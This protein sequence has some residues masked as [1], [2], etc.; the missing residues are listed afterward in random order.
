MTDDVRRIAESFRAHFPARAPGHRRLGREAEHPV[1][2][3]DGT[4]FDVAALWSDLAEGGGYEVLREGDLIVGL[5]GPDHIFSAEVGRGT[6]EI[7]VG[8]VD[9]VHEIGARYTAARDRLVRVAAAHGA[10]VLGY[11][12]QPITPATPELMTPKARYGLLLEAIGDAWLSFAATASDQVHVDVTLDEVVPVTNVLNLLGP[13]WTA[14]FANSSVAGGV[15]SGA[16]CL[17]ATSMGAIDA[18]VHR[19]GMPEAPSPDLEAWVARTLPMRHLMRRE[20]GVVTP[21]TGTFGDWLARVARDDAA[22]W[23]AW[24]W[25][26]HYVWNHARPR[27]HHG[28]VELRTPCQQPA[29]DHLLPTAL[30]TGVVQAHAD[31]AAFVHELLGPDA[32]DALARWAPDAAARG[33]AAPEPAEGLYDGLLARIRAGLVARGRGEED[34]LDG[35]EA[36]VAARHGPA[37]VAQEAFASGGAEALVAA[38]AVPAT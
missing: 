26:E 7:I 20:A 33:L 15:D 35:L 28:T 30:A 16:A 3:P 4:A 21:E 29:V 11:G 38:L 36:R 6:M 8:P 31:I 2:H 18:H 10:L 32:W 17:R 34:V 22:I 9:T 23:D 13:V 1:V 12:I 37:Q 19:H 25:H 14:W 24:L 5:E 27:A